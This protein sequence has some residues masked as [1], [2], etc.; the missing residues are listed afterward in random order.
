MKISKARYIDEVIPKNSLSVTEDVEVKAVD[1]APPV[2]YS[3]NDECE[4]RTLT[5]ERLRDQR[6]FKLTLLASEDQP[7]AEIISLAGLSIENDVE[8]EMI[9]GL[10]LRMTLKRR[11]NSKFPEITALELINEVA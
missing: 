10:K 5:F 6:L 8:D 3:G 11:N 9:I 4:R 7:L 2:E 1:Y